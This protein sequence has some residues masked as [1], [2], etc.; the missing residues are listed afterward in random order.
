MMPV[1]E[2]SILGMGNPL[3]DI[4]S[5]VD[6]SVLEKYGLDANSAIL[7]ED[8][9]I[10]MYAELCGNANVEYIA[11]GATQNS[12]RACQWMM[13]KETKATAYIGCIG[14]DKYGTMLKT[15]AE[16]D[17]V[18]TFYC[19]DEKAATGTCGVLITDHN[20]SLV[21]NLSAANCYKKDHLMSK[22]VWS[23]V[24][25]AELFYIGGFFLTVSPESIMAVAEHAYAENKVFCMNLSAPFLCEFFKEPMLNALP[26]W[27]II[28]GN[29]TEAQ[30]FAK[31]NNFKATTDIP[32]IALELAKLPK[33]NGA[34][35]RL[36]VI[37]QG[38]DQTVV[39]Q[40]GEI[41]TFP[42]KL[43]PKEKIVDTNGAGDA[44]V[45]GFLSQYVLGKPLEKCVEA[46]HYS[47]SVI[48]QR[49]GITFPEKCEYKA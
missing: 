47:S 5:V 8:K 46:A 10:P 42:V 14:N 25:N 21:A 38:H 37:T 2:L 33:K 27:D 48:I 17:G 39:V 15:C 23:A 41:K 16:N 12:I 18:A 29:E 40:N 3:L 32:A 28:F 13:G 22:S 45:G 20:R 26:Y 24:E 43:L 44:F 49:S 31:N 7:A 35:G 4:C 6:K 9:H 11:G 19:V 30:A 34:R 1:K 36:V